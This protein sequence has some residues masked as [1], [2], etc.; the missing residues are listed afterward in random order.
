MQHRQLPQQHQLRRI[1]PNKWHRR[2]HRDRRYRP[3][4]IQVGHVSDQLHSSVYQDSQHNATPQPQART[5]KIGFSIRTT[6]EMRSWLAICITL[7][8]SI[9]ALIAAYETS[10]D[11]VFG[12]IL[13]I[14]TLVL[15]YYFGKE[16]AGQDEQ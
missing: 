12:K 3:R 5:N 14:L 9:I 11:G 1:Q 2:S 16:T 4:R 13:P 8:A 6:D 15:G 10:A 7:L